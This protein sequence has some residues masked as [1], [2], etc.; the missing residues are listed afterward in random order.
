MSAPE[1]KPTAHWSEWQEHVLRLLQFHS[2][3]FTKID[4]D[5]R[6]LFIELGKIQVL[7]NFM[8]DTKMQMIKE[9]DSKNKQSALVKVAVITSI[10]SIIVA[11]LPY[12]VSLI[13]MIIH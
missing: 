7:N 8:H 11:L 6:T 10:S 4:A 13:K 3:Q 2:D 1:Q 5:I 12:L 9:R